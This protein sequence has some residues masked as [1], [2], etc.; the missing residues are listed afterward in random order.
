MILGI[1]SI[2]LPLHSWR[3]SLSLKPGLLMASLLA[4][5]TPCFYLM[6]RAIAPTCVSWVLQVEAVL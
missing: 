5:G 6:R 4:L 3:E 2:P 1:F